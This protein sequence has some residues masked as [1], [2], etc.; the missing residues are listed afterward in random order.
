MKVLVKC[1]ICN[2]ETSINECVFAA[3]KRV[4]EGE[5]HI[6]CCC[7]IAQRKYTLKKKKGTSA[8]QSAQNTFADARLN[9]RKR[10]SKC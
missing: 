9:S 7:Q 3:H 4:I 6:Y 5:E 8:E 1:E 2:A 10:K